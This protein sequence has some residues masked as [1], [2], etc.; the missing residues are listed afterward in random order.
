MSEYLPNSA[1]PMRTR[2][3]HSSSARCPRMSAT[4]CSAIWP[5]ARSAAPWLRSLLPEVEEPM[6]KPQVAARQPWCSAGGLHG[7]PPLPLPRSF[8]FSFTFI[9][10]QSLQALRRPTRWPAFIPQRPSLRKQNRPLPPQNPLCTARHQS[11][12]T[13]WSL[14]TTLL[15]KNPI[16]QTPSEVSQRCR[17]RPAMSVL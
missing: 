11:K 15:S 17:W 2:S 12:T 4:R 10:R 13:A 8:S 5:S 9:P 1:I 3:A 6:P 16:L 7:P 14:R